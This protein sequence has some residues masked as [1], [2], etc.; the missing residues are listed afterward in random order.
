MPC[1]YPSLNSVEEQ[2]AM[3]ELMACMILHGAGSYSM[4]QA[5]AMT[6]EERITE[7]SRMLK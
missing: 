6:Q 5:K 7:I 4:E 2:H 1:C 3:E